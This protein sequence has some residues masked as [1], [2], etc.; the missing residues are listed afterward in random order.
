MKKL[1]DA[2]NKGDM[3]TVK[4]VIEKN[5]SLINCREKGW[6]K[7]DEGESPLR[8]AI[9]NCHYDIVRFLT[10][11]GADVN[12]YTPR[13]SWYISHQ[14]IYTVVSHCIPR[15][16]LQCGTYE[17]SF[18][19]LKHLIEHQMDINLP[20]ENGVNSFFWGIN[21]SH[22]LIHSTANMLESDLTDE[23]IWDSKFDIKIAYFRFKEIFLLLLEHGADTDIPQYWKD[24][25]V[26]WDGFNV[27]IKWMNNLLTLCR[28]KDV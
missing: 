16:R 19:I 17:D 28:K 8:V 26:S 10:E 13:D 1:F 22:C 25:A 6:R 14:A 20:D 23:L 21:Q 2:I 12:D 3:E 24:K 5:A 4:A 15:Y 18:K 11:A 9:K 27:K 7:R